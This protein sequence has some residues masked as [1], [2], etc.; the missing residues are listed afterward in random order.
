VENHKPVNEMD[1]AQSASILKLDGADQRRG[2]GALRGP[3]WKLV[4]VLCRITI[5]NSM[6]Q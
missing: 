1:G 4:L 6:M 5:L 3:G 2:Q